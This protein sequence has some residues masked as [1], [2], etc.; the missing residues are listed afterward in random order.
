MQKI[1]HYLTI[2]SPTFTVWEAIHS[3]KGLSK[4]W[5]DRVK[6]KNGQLYF[7]VEK[8]FNPVMR[9]KEMHEPSRLQWECVDGKDLWKGSVISF[10]LTSDQE[11]THLLFRHHYANELPD[12][13]YGAFNF[14]WAYYLQS[15]QGYCRNGQ[16]KPFKP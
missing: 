14:N 11:V 4:W 8:S 5:T 15:L 7:T 1:I 12:Q 13:A 2:E 10:D 3:E 6:H 9:I 16:G